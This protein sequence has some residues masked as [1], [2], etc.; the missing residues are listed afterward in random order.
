M[1]RRKKKPA[2]PLGI[3]SNISTSGAKAPQRLFTGKRKANDLA[4]SGDSSE[5]AIRRPAPD[6]GSATLPANS[7]AV[8][9]EHAATC[10]WHLV[11]PREGRR[12]R[13]SWPGPSPLFSQVAHSRP[14]PWIHTRLNPQSCPRRL[15][16]FPG[17]W[18]TSRMAPLQTPRWPTPAY[19][20]G[21][22]LIKPPFYFRCTWQPYPS[23]LVAGVLP[24][25]SD[26]TT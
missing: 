23:G 24:L 10:R 8:M 16:S 18:A 20:Q 25:R 19:P 26:G 22:V 13:L 9:G 14:Q 1:S 5:N 4:S 3:R 15:A 21:S 17:L 2:V 12:T 11:S 6:A 7:T